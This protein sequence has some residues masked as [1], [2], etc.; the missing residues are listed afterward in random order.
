MKTTS[1]LIVCFVSIALLSFKLIDGNKKLGEVKQISG[2]Y[3]YINSTPVDAYDFI[4]KVD[5]PKIVKSKDYEDL[6][7]K[8]IEKAKKE[9]PFAEALLFNDGNLYSCEAVKF[10][11]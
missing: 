11:K 4:A 8:M 5:C 6:L 9:Q 3:I 2:V 10:K 7:P 1:L